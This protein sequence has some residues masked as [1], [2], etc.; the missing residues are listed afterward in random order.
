MRAQVA[1]NAGTDQDRHVMSSRLSAC[2][3]SDRTLWSAAGNDLA[4]PR[5]LN[6]HGN[7]LEV[8]SQRRPRHRRIVSA[9]FLRHHEMGD[10]MRASSRGGP[11]VGTSA[12]V[13][14][15]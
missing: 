13:K 2:L 7:C 5:P 10:E 14:S 11:A 3:R 8:Q 12:R 9:A 15:P 1:A 4:R 6:R